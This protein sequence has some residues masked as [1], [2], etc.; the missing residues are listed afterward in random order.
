MTDHSIEFVLFGSFCVWRCPFNDIIDIR[1]I[2]FVRL[3]TIVGL[4]LM[5]RPFAKY[6]LVRRRRGIFKAV[7]IT[8]DQPQ[9]F[10]RIVREKLEKRPHPVDP[11]AR[12]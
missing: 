8:P 12:Q 9:E 11:P 6:V 1:L 4:N 10:V 3:L 5:N 7:A 2:S